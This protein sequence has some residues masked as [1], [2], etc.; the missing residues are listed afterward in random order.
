MPRL[1]RIRRLHYMPL[2][3]Q[4]AV[5]APR[6]RNIGADQVVKRFLGRIAWPSFVLIV[7]GLCGLIITLAAT[8]KL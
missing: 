2:H 8:G 6:G 5:P 7:T 1:L 3:I 4:G